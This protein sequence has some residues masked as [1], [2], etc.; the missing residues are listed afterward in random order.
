[1]KKKYTVIKK[2]KYSNH[3]E[4]IN[5]EEKIHNNKEKTSKTVRD[6]KY[7]HCGEKIQPL[8]RKS[9]AIKEKKQNN[10]EKIQPS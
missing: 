6:K 1:M 2:K 4:K 7:S 3:D 5:H 9:T 10:Y 8:W